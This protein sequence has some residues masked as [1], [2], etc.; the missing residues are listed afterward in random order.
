MLKCFTKGV[1]N[2]RLLTR[3]LG[4]NVDDLVDYGCPKVQDLVG[5]GKADSSSVCSCYPFRQKPRLH[6]AER[7]SKVYGDWAM[8]QLNS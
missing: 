8:Q 3:L 7:K 2:C 5:G 4:Q 1:E 6:F